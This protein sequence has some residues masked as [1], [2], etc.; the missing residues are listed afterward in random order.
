MEEL[1]N[2]ITYRCP[3]EGKEKLLKPVTEQEIKEVLFSMPNDKSPGPDGYTTEFYKATWDILGVEFVVA[4]QSFFAKGFLP[5]GVNS[6]I[7]ALIP[8][9][10]EAMEMKDYRPISCCNVIYKV[11]SKIIANRLKM[12]LPQFIAGNQSA[13]IKDRLLIENLLLATEIV[14]DYHKVSISERCAIKIDISKAFDS[15]QWSF[16]KNVLLTLDFPQEFVH[17]IMLCVTTASFSVQV[18]GELA[19]FFNSSRGLRQGCSLSPYLFVIVM[20]VLSKQLDRAA[21]LQQFGYHP[22]CKKLGLTH[23]SFADDI[24]VLSDGK[25]R[26]LEGIVSV[27][28]SFAKQSG[29]KISMEKTTIYLASISEDNR[30]EIESH[31]HFAVGCLPVKYLG[32]P[33]VT[34]RLTSTDYNPLLEQIKRRIGTWTARFLSYAGRL[35]LVSSVLW[36]ICNFWLAAFRL[37]RDCIREIDKLCSAF[38]WSGPELNTNKAKIAWEIVCKPKREGGLGLR[39]LREAN[40][41]CCLKLIWRIA[42]HGDSLWVK[43]TE[44]YFLKNHNFWSFRQTNKGSWMWRKLLKYREIAKAF[45][46]VDVGNGGKV[47]FWYDDWSTMGRLIEVLG[48]RGQIDMGISKYTNLAAAWDGRRPRTWKETTYAPVC[49]SQQHRARTAFYEAE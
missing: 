10:M 35:N 4:V 38:L 43:W 47:S 3:A 32:L 25:V 9:T 18:N 31:F 16:L 34:K 15:V 21:G 22:K 42:S 44:A 41:V 37:P 23:I 7:L 1:G 48:D 5:K 27:F 40:D 17:W 24:M 33:L 46:K 28:D 49:N 29:L 20:D 19:G 14:K 45:S 11:I 26:S 39:P 2:L 13:F 36:S 30:R 6:T 8:K 12:V